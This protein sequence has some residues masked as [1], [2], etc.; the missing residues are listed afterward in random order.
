MVPIYHLHG[1]TSFK[2]VIFKNKIIIL[3][4][5]HCIGVSTH[6]PETNSVS[7]IKY[8]GSYSGHLEIAA[9]SH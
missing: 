1:V 6:I 4:I 2:T 9:V 8:N 5:V 3:D 7:T